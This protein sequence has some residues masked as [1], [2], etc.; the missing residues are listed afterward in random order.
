[1]EHVKEILAGLAIF[2]VVAGT[3][4]GIIGGFVYSSTQN[5]DKQQRLNQVCIEKGYDGWEDNSYTH[6]HVG[7]VK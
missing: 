7:C 6:G 4:A 5:S 1:M 2:I 3:I